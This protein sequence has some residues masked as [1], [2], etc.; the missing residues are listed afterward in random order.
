MVYVWELIYLNF[1]DVIFSEMDC[2][3]FGKGDSEPIVYFDA[4]IKIHLQKYLVSNDNN[5]SLLCHFENFTFVWKFM[6]L[7][8]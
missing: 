1:D 5:S 2:V 7:K 8:K 4:K 6:K 3:V